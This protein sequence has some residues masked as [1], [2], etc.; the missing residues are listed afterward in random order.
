MTRRIRMALLLLVAAF[1][2]CRSMPWDRNVYDV[3]VEGVEDKALVQDL[4]ALSE[5]WLR[6]NERG[7]L[8]ERPGR[9]F[10]AD[11]IN[12]Q[13]YLHAKGYRDATVRSRFRRQGRPTVIFEVAH[14][15]PYRISRV[16]VTGEM[17]HV[18]LP[19]GWTS[20]L[21]GAE[22]DVT[23]ARKAGA[24]LARA[25][26]N[27]GYPD[28]G[29]RDTV[30]VL[31]RKDKE[32]EV[33]FSVHAGAPAV[34]GELTVEGLQ[35]VKKPF[36]E[37]RISWR[38]GDS[39]RRDNLDLFRRRLSESGL[40]SYV[41]LRGSGRDATSGVYDVTLTLRER[42]RRTIGLGV[43]YQT[44]TGP[45]AK[46]QWQHRNL[47]GMGQRLEVDATY[48]RDLW[49]G[50]VA[51][52]L[53]GF[54]HPDHDFT[55]GLKASEEDT[56]AYL[57]R[58]Q[59]YYAQFQHRP[60]RR[61]MLSYGPAFRATDATEGTNETSYLQASFPVKMLRNGRDDDLNPSRGYAV[62]AGWEP[63]LDLDEGH[64]YQRMMLTPSVYLPLKDDVLVLAA[65]MT[66]GSL[67]GTEREHIPP[68]LRFYAGG[69]QSVRG[70]AYQSVGPREEGLRP[71]GR[72]LLETSLELR[73]RFARNLGVVLF[74]DGGS[75]YEPEFPDFDE[76]FQWGAGLGFRYMTGVGPLRVDF[77]VPVN[78]R[79]DIDNDFEFYISI[80]Q[81][82]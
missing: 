23:L 68:D 63:F 43:G 79:D 35:R 60:S 49:L 27:E 39:Y 6:R 5:A 16:T 71:G 52:T 56:D 9:A 80:G 41:D 69:G 20:S 18:F 19:P 57:V 30:M 11:A 31:D 22:A 8:V 29:I 38:P 37:N 32:A 2:A 61:W 17:E 62:A 51:F 78:P 75:A 45:E 73:W 81:A 34:M 36:V 24:A 40:F 25:L 66:I 13:R 26:Q 54:L 58:Y 44:D 46:V 42:K 77:G 48:A 55:L 15:T 4:L 70:Y 10:P 67:S 72:S 59:T 12:M 76:S 64:V 47:F 65:R 33:L 74:V 14:L 50:S 82:F 53:P 7:A 1:P 3:T 28:A 21:A